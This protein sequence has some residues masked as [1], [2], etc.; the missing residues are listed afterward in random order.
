M[1]SYATLTIGSFEVITS[2]NEINPGLIWLFRPSEKSISRIDKRN[3]AELAHYIEEDHLDDYNEENP[4]IRVRYECKVYE[5]RDRLELK[6]YT[7]RAVIERFKSG[8][9][10]EIVQIEDLVRRDTEVFNFVIKENRDVLNTLIFESWLDGFRRIR[11]EGLTS[12]TLREITDEDCQLPLLRYMLLYAAPGLNFPLYDELV[13]LR[14]IIDEFPADT[15]VVY[16]LSDLVAG[17]YVDDVDDHVAYAETMMLSDVSLHGRVIV[18]VEGKSDR[19]ILHRSLSLLLPHLVDYFH[20]FDFASW[21][22]EGGA[23]Q[24]VKILRSF[25]A[26]DIRHRILALFDN[27]T[28]AKSAL[29]SLDLGSL[30]ENIVVRH[31]PALP[32]A[33]RYPTLGPTGQSEMDINGL[34]GGL[35]LYLGEDVLRDETGDLRPVQ[36]TGFDKKLQRYQGE[37]LDKNVIQGEFNSKLRAC[38]KDPTSVASYDWD[39]INRIFDVM[40]ATFHHVD[41]EAI[42]EGSHEEIGWL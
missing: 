37:L 11:S 16:D 5:A 19:E 24:L 7:R 9:Q 14:A 26:A 28:A 35:E 41:E 27:D 40:V 17:G 38:E 8:V 2:R 25:A 21:T 34:A 18:L 1:S 33:T 20:F 15:S 31:Y 13:F 29:T 30:P 10:R 32:I 36:W 6:G 12:K 4:F 42:I 23:G 22:A 3:T 39:G